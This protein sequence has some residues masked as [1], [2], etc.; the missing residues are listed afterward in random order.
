MAVHIFAVNE[1][2]YEVCIRHGLVG[3]P[4]PKES[5]SKNNIFDGLLSRLAAI[6]E[7]DYILMYVIGSKE[8]RGLW[9]AEGR[10]FFD[11]TSVWAD[12][13]YPFR[14]KIKCTRYSF[15]N[16]LRLNDINDLRSNGRIWTW[17]LQR[18][19]G[20]N[21]MFSIS[22]H[23]FDILL[24]EYL[25][26]NPFTLTR[27]VIR[28]PYPFHECN[29]IEQIHFVESQPQYEFSIMALLN[30][31]FADGSY[32]DIFGNYSDYLCY[33]PT[34]LGTEMDFL[35]MFESPLNQHQVVSYDI[36]E[37]KRAEFAEDALKQLIG[38]ESWFLQKKV[39]GDLNMIRTTAIAKSFS[40][41]V[42]DYVKKRTKFENKPI[43][44]FTYNFDT[45]NN[46]LKLTQIL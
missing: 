26:I 43:K 8:L 20:S 38:Y 24:N 21:A 29:L 28:E 15:Q 40:D 12:R 33:V 23:E 32:T 41:V 6:R 31:A 1:D 34:N 3:L 45:G 22:N 44:L 7:N 9:Q 5:R 42:V 13:I 11:T 16:Y 39:S 10:P 17:A 4:E 18:A 27:N 14:C 37:V 30:C 35:L 25:K 19:S 36:I 46:R 2:N